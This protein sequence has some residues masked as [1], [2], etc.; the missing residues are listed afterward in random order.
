MSVMATCEAYRRLRPHMGRSLAPRLA[1]DFPI[2]LQ[3]NKSDV[4]MPG[5]RTYPKRG[6]W[7]VIGVLA[8]GQPSDSF[9]SHS[10]YAARP[11]AQAWTSASLPTI[12]VLIVMEGA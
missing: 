2:V 1:G 11:A 3:R 8:L 9:A 4:C 10:C 5:N 12:C 7:C 6:E